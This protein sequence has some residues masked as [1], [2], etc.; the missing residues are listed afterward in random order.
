M[1]Y[2]HHCGSWE[3]VLY[4]ALAPFKN[5]FLPDTFATLLIFSFARILFNPIKAPLLLIPP[6]YYQTLL[7][8]LLDGCS[9]VEILPY[10]WYNIT[11]H[12]FGGS[13]KESRGFT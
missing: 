8:Q 4:H 13:N 7:F 11:I 6:D 1:K 12:G 9:Q 5:S 10:F 2:Y 3:S